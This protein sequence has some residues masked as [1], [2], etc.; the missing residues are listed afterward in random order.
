MIIK[1]RLK[2]MIDMFQEIYRLLKILYDYISNS[3]YRLREFNK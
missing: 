1:Q 2:K 3:K